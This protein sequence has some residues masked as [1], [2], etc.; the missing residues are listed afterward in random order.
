[1]LKIGKKIKIGDYVKLH[2]HQSIIVCSLDNVY[3]SIKD[4]IAIIFDSDVDLINNDM[5]EKYNQCKSLSILREILD[6]DVNYKAKYGNGYYNHQLKFIDI[7]YTGEI[8]PIYEIVYI[9]DKKCVLPK[10]VLR[11]IYDNIVLVNRVNKI[12]KYIEFFTN[13]ENYYNRVYKRYKSN[14]I[15]IGN[16]YEEKFNSFIR[17]YKLYFI[18]YL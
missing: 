16:P 1:M 9:F 3:N 10:Y 7:C 15:Q 17:K 11:D 2:K 12:V 5:I 8:S 13:S 14:F 6:L 4:N 18:E